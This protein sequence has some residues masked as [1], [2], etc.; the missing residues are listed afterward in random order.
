MYDHDR[1]SELNPQVYERPAS[2]K[3]DDEPDDSDFDSGERL[4]KQESY[5]LREAIRDHVPT[6]LEA[7]G[8]QG[9]I[10]VADVRSVFGKERCKEGFA[11]DRLNELV[12]EGVLV[13]QQIQGFKVYFLKK[14]QT[15]QNSAVEEILESTP[16]SIKENNDSIAIDAIDLK[17]LKYKNKLNSLQQK[18]DCLEQSKKILLEGDDD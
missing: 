5:E 6:F 2:G 8:Q 15:E 13:S 10:T 11:R 9:R 3:S 18:I 17:L 14:F 16:I 1:L 4:T 12:E 7:Q